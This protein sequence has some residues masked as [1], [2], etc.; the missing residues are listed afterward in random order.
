MANHKSAQKRA[1]QSL[2]RAER[3]QKIKST[4]KTA[5]K[6]LVTAASQKSATVKQLLSQYTTKLMQAVAKGVVKKQT[7][8]RKL[9]RV[10][11]KVNQLLQA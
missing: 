9:S 8:S 11:T 3:N 10:Q 7:M 1:R 6:K 4:V 5:E 2:K